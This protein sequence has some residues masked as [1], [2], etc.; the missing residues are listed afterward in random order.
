M[1]N[2]EEVIETWK[3]EYE[4]E[5]EERRTFREQWMRYRAE[6]EGKRWLK[7]PRWVEK[8]W[9]IFKEEYA[10]C[11]VCKSEMLVVCKTIRN[12]IN[13]CIYECEHCRY[14]YAGT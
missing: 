14:I 11:P 4:R 10:E 3:R 8:G 1:V 2:K 12:V 7:K 5:I 6:Q 9:W 13:A